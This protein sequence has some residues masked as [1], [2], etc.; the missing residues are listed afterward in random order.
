MDLL[1][2]SWVQNFKNTLYPNMALNFKLEQIIYSGGSIA[3]KGP[4]TKFNDKIIMCIQYTDI[5]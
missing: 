5:N 2:I 1:L 3:E 4:K